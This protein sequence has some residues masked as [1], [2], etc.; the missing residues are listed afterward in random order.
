[1]EISNDFINELKKLVSSNQMMII[2]KDNKVRP[3]QDVRFFQDEGNRREGPG[4]R[5]AG[6]IQRKRRIL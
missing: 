3:I 6:H 4:E 2:D 5:G 1:M